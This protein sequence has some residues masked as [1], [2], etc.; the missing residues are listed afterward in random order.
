MERDVM[1]KSRHEKEMSRKRDAKEQECQDKG[2]RR[3]EMSRARESKRK[4]CHATGM[5]RDLLFNAQLVFRTSFLRTFFLVYKPEK[6]K[7][8]LHR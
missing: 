8:K 6:S 5:S 4:R 2:T 7:S 1:N 3:K